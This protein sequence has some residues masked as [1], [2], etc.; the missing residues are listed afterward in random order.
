LLKNLGPVDQPLRILDFGCGVGRNTFGAAIQYPKWFVIGYDNDA[1]L[2][3]K[4]EFFTIHYKPPMPLN[5]VFTSDW[6]AVK[7]QQ[8]DVI[9]CSLVLQHIYEDALVTYLNDFR[10]IT[11]KLIVS[12]RRINDDPANKSTWSILEANGWSPKEF[13][14]AGAVVSY[15]PEGSPEEHN[16]AI[17]ETPSI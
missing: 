14:S 4:E 12:G 6:E 2:S 17:Y 8:F 3:K 13:L 10:S 5:V 7:A 16:T 11:K 9:F 15:I 1:M